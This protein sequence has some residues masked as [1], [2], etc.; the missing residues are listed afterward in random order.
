MGPLSP[1]AHM[2]RD[3][4][5]TFPGRL[6]CLF[7]TVMGSCLGFGAVRFFEPELCEGPNLLMGKGEDE[8]VVKL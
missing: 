1:T 4:D 3:S 2:H 7:F 5:P 8:K 6:R